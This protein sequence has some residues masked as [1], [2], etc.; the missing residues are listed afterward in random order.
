MKYREFTI[1]IEEK[2]SRY[3]A[4]GRWG[5]TAFMS[6]QLT[7]QQAIASVM[8]CIDYWWEGRE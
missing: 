1:T 6:E 8:L 4:R 3:I 7:E 5:L 2:N